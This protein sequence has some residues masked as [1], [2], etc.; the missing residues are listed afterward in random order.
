M[1]SHTIRLIGPWQVQWI[2]PADAAGLF[3]T[4][5]SVTMPREWTSLFGDR[6]GTARFTRGFNCPTNLDVTE[7][8]VVVF[9][10]VGGSG[11]VRINDVALGEIAAEVDAT[12]FDITSQLRKRNELVVELTFDPRKSVPPG[13]LY[14]VV[15]LRI[16]AE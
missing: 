4:P 6:A 1:S 16:D 7:R 14:D 13:G 15:A 5:Q 2:A 9:D 3:D 10:G 8:V 12:A 11:E